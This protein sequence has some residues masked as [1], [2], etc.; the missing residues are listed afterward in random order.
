MKIGMFSPYLPKHFGGGERHFLTTAAYLSQQHNVEI[1]LAEI[2]SDLKSRV[3]T[4]EERFDLDLSAI[5]WKE[6]GLA[7]G[8]QSALKTWQET[9][10]YDAFFFLT[11]GSLFLNGSRRGVLHVQIPFTQPLTLL[12]KLKLRT[13]Q[14]L[15]TNSEF[16]KEVIERSWQRSVD[17]VHA[18]FVDT[19]QIPE[20]LPKKQPEILT[21]G[22]FFDP[23]SAGQNKR[24]DILIRA[25][26]DGCKKNIWPHK[27]VLHVAGA[28]EPGKHHEEYVDSLKE[29]AKNYP[30]EFHLDAPHQEIVDLYA[31]CEVYWHATGFEVS[32]ID[33]PELV[34]HFGMTPLEAQA[35][36]CIPI[37]VPKGGLTETVSNGDTGWYYT[38]QTELLEKTLLVFSLNTQEKNIW[39]QRVRNAAERYSLARFCHTIDQMIQTPRTL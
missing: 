37:V 6:S 30:V 20:K 35:W 33:H 8:T 21:V 9:R 12:G 25:F 39:Q 32:E 29:L 15:N 19:A 17:V 23:E 14:V 2:P 13:W 4:Y 26:I 1:L 34:E 22:R 5:H 3:H 18:P 31:R 7:T 36:G 28:V 10:S 16:T 27:T 38:T 24:H 11:D